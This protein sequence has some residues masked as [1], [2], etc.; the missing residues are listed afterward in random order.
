MDYIKP[1]NIDQDLLNLISQTRDRM[2]I[3]E[4]NFNYEENELLA[5]SYIYEM[6]AL[7]CRH[8]YYLTLS[9][10]DLQKNVY[11]KTT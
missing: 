3:L 6:K 11:H 7:E 5:N 2:K 1:K 8:S 4:N 10:K 9:K